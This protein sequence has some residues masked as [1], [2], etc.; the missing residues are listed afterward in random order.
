[1]D[2]AFHLSTPGGDAGAPAPSRA[3]AVRNRARVLSTTID[4]L[5]SKGAD[6][7]VDE[8]ARAAGVG[9]GTVVRSFG[10][11]QKL[12]DCAVAELLRPVVEQSRAAAQSPQAGQMLG[13]LL[14]DLALFHRE[15][16]VLN[17]KLTSMSMPNAERL[18]EELLANF[19]HVVQSAQRAGVVR[20]D[21]T[22][23]DVTLLLA[24][25][26]RAADE[27]LGS[28][29]QLR[30]YITIVTD[31]LRPAHPT[32]LPPVGRRSPRSKQ[33]GCAP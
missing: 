12:I 19:T 33:R 32:E 29:D 20:P 21:I 15:S 9:A 14:L 23:A 6:V 22:M 7:S 3:D 25:V 27:T 10:G 17:A 24:G 2:G 11:K 16:R 31:G 13:Q 18:Q 5:R 4:M 1:M 30:R 8:I 28:V 26:E